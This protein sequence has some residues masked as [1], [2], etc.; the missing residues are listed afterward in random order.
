M[1]LQAGQISIVF[2]FGVVLFLLF[3]ESRP[4]LAGAALVPCALKPHLFLPFAIV[5]LSE[6]GN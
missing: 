6:K 4:W 5:L 3:Y 2:L 1:C